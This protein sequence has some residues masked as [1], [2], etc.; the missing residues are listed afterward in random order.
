MKTSLMEKFEKAVANL[1]TLKKEDLLNLIYQGKTGKEGII[2]DIDTDDI[3]ALH[4][5]GWETVN[6][7]FFYIDNSDGSTKEILDIR[8]MLPD[9]YAE[10]IITLS[11]YMYTLHVLTE[12]GM[13]LP[14]LEKV[15]MQKVAELNLNK[16]IYCY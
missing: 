14:E 3:L 4:M 5:Q 2:E 11:Q 10:K 6:P 13:L 8:V 7:F 9:H 12:N 16:F 1:L 15:L